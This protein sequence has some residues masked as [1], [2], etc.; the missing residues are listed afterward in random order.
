MLD[1][2]I[3]VELSSS[4]SMDKE[5]I[6]TIVESIFSNISKMLLVGTPFY[7]ENIGTISVEDID[8]IEHSNIHKKVRRTVFYQKEEKA[9]Y[10]TQT[11]ALNIA[12]EHHEDE[13]KVREIINKTFA[14]MSEALTKEKQISITNFG[15]FYTGSNITFLPS[16][17]LEYLINPYF[18]MTKDTRLA[19]EAVQTSDNSGNNSTKSQATEN[20]KE[21]VESLDDYDDIIEEQKTQENKNDNDIEE[22][23]I[24]EVDEIGEVG[25]NIEENVAEHENTDKK[26]QAQESNEATDDEDNSKDNDCANNDESVEDNGENKN[27]ENVVLKYDEVFNKQINEPF[28]VRNK[29][30]SEGYEINIKEENDTQTEKKPKKIHKNVVL[31]QKKERAWL[32]VTISALAIIFILS[33]TILMFYKN[34]LKAP[35]NALDTIAQIFEDDKPPKFQN[36]NMYDIAE[37]YFVRKGSQYKT[38]IVSK[39]IHYWDISKMV[40]GETV[41]WPFIYALNSDETDITKNEAFILKKGDRIN[42]GELKQNVILSLF[43]DMDKDTS[44]TLAE[45]YFAFYKQFDN[46]QNHEKAMSMI[47]ISGKLDR[48][49]LERKKYEI[50]TV[51]YDI[52]SAN[53]DYKKQ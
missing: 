11:L 19:L 27:E 15:S 39:D 26:D 30:R 32:F 52:V 48:D 17:Y 13:Q 33:A 50:P 41:Y 20:M 47:M 22:D 43:I 46:A 31:K 25:E 44:Q 40:Y 29:K 53:L 38:Y 36:D 6:D 2:N 37:F 51:V 5:K 49:I 45:L 10:S 3:K 16:F 7:I 9:Y 14:Y 21:I 42:V 23:L 4:L 12:L 28:T 34:V 35:I 18:N 8:S 1:E 24:E